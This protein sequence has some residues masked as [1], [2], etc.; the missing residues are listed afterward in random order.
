MCISPCFILIFI[1]EYPTKE[2]PVGTRRKFS[3]E[4]SP[5][6]T[7]DR[8]FNSDSNKKYSNVQ[9]TPNF[10]E[11]KT[12]RKK[13]GKRKHSLRPLSTNNDLNTNRK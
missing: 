13:L 8:L 12:G 1:S 10:D 2:R 6:L 11:A 7:F 3:S 9:R 4:P 5:E